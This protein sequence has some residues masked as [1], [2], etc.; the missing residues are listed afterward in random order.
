M[1][2][3]VRAQSLVNAAWFIHEWMAKLAQL[4]GSLAECLLGAGL[5]RIGDSIF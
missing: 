3:L 2:P 1:W 4:L 5:L